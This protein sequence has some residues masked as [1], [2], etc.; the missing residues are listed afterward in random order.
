[1]TL[2]IC[3]WIYSIKKLEMPNIITSFR[4]SKVKHLPHYKPDI[5][6]LKEYLENPIFPIIL[7]ENTK[8]ISQGLSKKQSPNFSKGSQQEEELNKL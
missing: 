2:K 7:K 4:L 6:L 1:M 5:S 8:P 3:P